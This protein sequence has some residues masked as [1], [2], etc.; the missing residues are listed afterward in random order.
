MDE[1]GYPVCHFPPVIVHLEFCTKPGP[2]QINRPAWSVFCIVICWHGPASLG[3]ESYAHR[4]LLAVLC[5]CH[6]FVLHQGSADDLDF[7][8]TRYYYVEVARVNIYETIAS[9]A[10]SSSKYLAA[11]QSGSWVC[12]LSLRRS[13]RFIF[14]SLMVDLMVARLVAPVFS[15][16]FCFCFCCFHFLSIFD[17]SCIF[18]SLCI[19]RFVPLFASQ[20]SSSFSLRGEEGLASAG[21]VVGCVS[22]FVIV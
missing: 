11:A 6:R 20:D 12:E 16:F 14:V 19:L 15:V 4:R 22:V 10:G 18:F 2:Q 17:V 21:S 9:Y 3:A 1:I 7:R 8:D 13:V 5:S